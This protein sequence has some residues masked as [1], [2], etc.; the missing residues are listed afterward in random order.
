MLT[1][2][3]SLTGQGAVT[4]D[5]T[6]GGMLSDKEKSYHINAPELSAVYLGLETFFQDAKN[7]PIPLTLK[8]TMLIALLT[9][10]RCQTIP[11]R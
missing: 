3:A 4:N 6:T 8:L 2:D 11:I 9:G 5:L 10:Q 1:T 7:I